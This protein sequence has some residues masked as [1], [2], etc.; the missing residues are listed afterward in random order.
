MVAR[1]SSVLRARPRA[2]RESGYQPDSIVVKLFYLEQGERELVPVARW[3]LDAMAA[4]LVASANSRL[5]ML[6]DSE[7]NIT[8]KRIFPMSENLRRCMYCS[9]QEL[10]HGRPV[11]SM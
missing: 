11:R 5:G 1:R 10:R 3:Q 8:K 7:H 2:E 6:V 4:Q 9:H